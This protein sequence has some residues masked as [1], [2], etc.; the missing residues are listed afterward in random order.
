MP[1]PGRAYYCFELPVLR[2]PSQHGLGLFGGGDKLGGVT[3][4]AGLHLCRDL[5]PG[6]TSADF[7]DLLY[8]EADTVAEIENI[9]FPA[10]HEI[11]KGQYVR[12]GQVGDMYVVPDAAAVPGGVVVAENG[13]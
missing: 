13:Q 8:G 10:L 5:A 1:F 11:V 4:A 9:A 6:H 2:A 7:Y 12:L 3:R